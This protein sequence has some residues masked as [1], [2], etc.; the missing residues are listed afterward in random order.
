[1]TA[2][3]LR[4]A[5]FAVGLFALVA[6]SVANAQS[7]A[8]V[9]RREEARRERVVEP[10]KVYSNDDLTPDFTVPP[11]P[12]TPAAAPPPPAEAENEPEKADGV[13][14]EGQAVSE[15]AVRTDDQP[16]DTKGEA[17]WR[18]RAS[19]LR[20]RVDAQRAQVAALRTRAAELAGSEIPT[21]ARERE[22]TQMTLLKA[23]SDLAHF[24][25]DLADFELTARQKN[26]PPA[27]IQ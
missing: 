2:H 1:M 16:K 11:P 10:V 21:A 27:W 14:P 3:R 7:L 9:A 19:T 22:L 17:F 15:D 24:E 18:D 5:A 25:Q 23:Q 26:I 12:E 13:Q 8:D 20:N 4:G 6:P